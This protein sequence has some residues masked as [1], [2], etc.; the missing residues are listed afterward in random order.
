MGQRGLVKFFS[1]KVMSTLAFSFAIGY[2]QLCIIAFLSEYGQKLEIFGNSI[3]DHFFHDMPRPS[4]E[5]NIPAK[6]QIT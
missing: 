6:S 2:N 3:N 5:P 1:R 4:R